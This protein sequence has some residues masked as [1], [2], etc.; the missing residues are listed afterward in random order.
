MF[1]KID[2]WLFVWVND[3]IRKGCKIVLV[4][5]GVINVIVCYLILL[6]DILKESVVVVFLLINEFIVVLFILK[7]YFFDSVN[8][9]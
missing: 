4:I 1:Y 8:C 2:C 3:C 5:I 9:F 7:V 6:Y